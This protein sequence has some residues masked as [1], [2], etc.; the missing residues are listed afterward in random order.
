MATMRFSSRILAANH[1]AILA[2]NIG[3]ET[4]FG[5]NGF[6]ALNLGGCHVPKSEG[7]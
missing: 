4:N 7:C 1:L 2:K 3:C 6:E 5:R